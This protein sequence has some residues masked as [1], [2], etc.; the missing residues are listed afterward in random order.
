MKRNETKASVARSFTTSMDFFRGAD[1]DVSIR[2][3]LKII[4][5]R[6]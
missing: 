1:D 5:N 2:R 3:Q 4:V 6:T